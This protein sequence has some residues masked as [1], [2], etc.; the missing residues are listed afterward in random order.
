MTLQEGYGRGRSNLPFKHTEESDARIR[1][2][3][4]AGERVLNIA[5][6]LGVSRNVI[7]GRARRIGLAV[8][9]SQIDAARTPDA[10][11]RNSEAQKSAWAGDPERRIEMSIR[12]KRMHRDPETHARIMSAMYEGRDLYHANRKANH[13]TALPTEPA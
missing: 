9:G 13:S 4:E 8:F 2:G 6:E 3:Y 10:R 1:R 12:S 11:N 7:I 5:N